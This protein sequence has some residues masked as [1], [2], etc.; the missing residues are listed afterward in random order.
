[1]FFFFSNS[2]PHSPHSLLFKRRKRSK[3]SPACL[4]KK[5]GARFT[6]VF[7]KMLHVCIYRRVLQHACVCTVTL[8]AISVGRVK[9]GRTRQICAHFAC[10]C[11]EVGGGVERIS[12]RSGISVAFNLPLFTFLFNEHISSFKYDSSQ[13][14][15]SFPKPRSLADVAV[16][17]PKK[18]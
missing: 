16:Q 17:H 3:K 9:G 6:Y 13:L 5:S 2:R 1:M 7:C 12:D 11:V 10:L 14:I 18:N 15:I 8:P 4:K